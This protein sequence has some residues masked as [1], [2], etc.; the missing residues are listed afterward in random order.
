MA[1]IIKGIGPHSLG[2]AFKQAKKP[3][4]FSKKRKQLQSD[5][6]SGS[7]D[8]SPSIGYYTK[9]K[10]DATSPDG[11][12]TGGGDYGKKQKLNKYTDVDPEVE[13]NFR[14][15]VSRPGAST[16][17]SDPYGK[18]RK[19]S[20]NKKVYYD[21]DTP[22]VYSEGGFIKDKNNVGKSTIVSDYMKKNKESGK[23][24]INYKKGDLLDAVD[25]VSKIKYGSGSGGGETYKNT[26][27]YKELMN[28]V[29]KKS[30]KFNSYSATAGV[31]NSGKLKEGSISFKNPSTGRERSAP[32]D[33]GGRDGWVSPETMFTGTQKMMER[34]QKFTGNNKR[35]KFQYKATNA[36]GGQVGSGRRPGQLGMLP[37]GAA[38][39]INRRG[40]TRGT[41]GFS[42]YL[43][44]RMNVMEAKTADRKN[45]DFKV[46]SSSN[47]K[48]QKAKKGY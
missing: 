35:Q 37:L 34:F 27:Q 26:P 30:N 20:Y 33:F 5:I 47:K 44:E 17:A 10:N 2:S 18:D 31:N 41:S 25:V 38:E 6:N 43:T 42:D 9:T 15:F 32:V 7:F 4:I 22:S 16:L 3:N 29:N 46:K 14:N 45:S 11:T 24:K 19:R 12:M 1:N 13:G 8:I 21:K 40:T 28:K 39:I 23:A 48:K 36:E